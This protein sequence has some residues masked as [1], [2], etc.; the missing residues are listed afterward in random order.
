MCLTLGLIAGATVVIRL[1]F[2]QFFS[3]SRSLESDDWI[4]FSCLPLGLACIIL[5][6]VGLTA[7]G[8]GRD[9]WG[10]PRDNLMEFAK[11]FYVIQILYL[12]LIALI[13]LSLCFFYLKIFTGRTTRILLWFMVVFHVGYCVGFAVGVV[14]QCIPIHYQWDRYD[15]EN[16]PTAMGHCININ[17]AGWGNGATNIISDFF[18]L[19]IP[20]S[21]IRKLKLHWKKKIG[22]ALMFLTGAM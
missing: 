21:Q 19:G 20:L 2:K 7:N 18:L 15:W 3:R 12:I 8:L 11:Y 1:G 14:F 6:V 9:M 5:E 17:A 10:L 4:I 22:V 16:G 13:K